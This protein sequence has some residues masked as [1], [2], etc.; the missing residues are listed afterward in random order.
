MNA[1]PHWQPTTEAEKSARIQSL[2]E[3]FEPDEIANM[4]NI[5]PAE[6]HAALSKMTR[7]KWWA[8]DNKTGRHIV[9]F[10]QRGAYLR[11]CLLGWT[12]WDWGI[13]EVGQGVQP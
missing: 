12:D 5:R 4:L 2:A 13:G 11:V 7:A 1:S 6:V 3:R 9:A 10:G 8:R